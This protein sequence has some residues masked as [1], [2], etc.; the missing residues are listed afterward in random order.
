MFGTNTQPGSFG[1]QQPNNSI[2][3]QKPPS[4]GIFGNSS[5]PPQTGPVRIYLI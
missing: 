3:G 2:F 1:T 5:N 4:G